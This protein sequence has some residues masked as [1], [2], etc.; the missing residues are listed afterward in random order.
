M[1]KTLQW[2]QSLGL[3]SNIID[4]ACV[5]S[6]KKLFVCFRD[7]GLVESTDRLAKLPLKTDQLADSVHA[8]DELVLRNV[9]F[10]VLNLEMD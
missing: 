8:L 10:R 9:E 4:V 3:F 2:Y 7:S 5:Q 6:L 1:L